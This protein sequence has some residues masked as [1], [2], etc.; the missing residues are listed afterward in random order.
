MPL[1]R[2]KQQEIE[3]KL[4]F[5]EKKTEEGDFKIVILTDEE[6]KD[7]EKKKVADPKAVFPEVECLTT[8]WRK[9]NWELEN[10]IIE[11]SQIF[12]EITGTSRG[13]WIKYRD[14]KFKKCLK[15]WDLKD[16]DKNPILLNDMS[17]NSLPETVV[18]A[19]ISKY[20]DKVT[21]KDTERKN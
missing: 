19:L 5:Y 18:Y 1:I 6:A 8:K 4:Y 13:S 12:D 9:F 20:D 11:R 17:I 3:V 14:L 7:I 16:E 2:K 21:L 10:E 15:S